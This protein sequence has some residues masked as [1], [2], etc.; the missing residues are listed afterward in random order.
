[1]KTLV[2]L[3]LVGGV[4]FAEPKVCATSPADATARPLKVREKAGVLVA[5]KGEFPAI[6]TDGKRLAQLFVDRDA[7]GATESHVEIWQTADRNEIGWEGIDP[8]TRDH[9]AVVDKIN[10]QLDGTWRPIPIYKPCDAAATTLQLAD[11][12]AF[13]LE[14]DNPQ[15]SVYRSVN[16]KSRTSML[17]IFSTFGYLGNKPV[18]AGG[19]FCGKVT[20]IAYGFGGLTEGVAVI[21]PTGDLPKG[22]FVA[23]TAHS[24]HI[25]LT[26]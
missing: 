6:S 22:C 18:G 12:L 15:T 3:G 9:A 8:D 20:R 21:V 13:A 25:Y 24:A 1:M 26:H 7:E 19:G 11:G 10:R 23:P 2:I 4:A 14:P 5:A 17:P 16:G